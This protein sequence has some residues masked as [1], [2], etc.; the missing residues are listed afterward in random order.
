[1]MSHPLIGV[2]HFLYS[3][4]TQKVFEWNDW[5]VNVIVGYTKKASQ[6]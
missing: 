2:T 4:S 3:S 6:L 5:V 1:M